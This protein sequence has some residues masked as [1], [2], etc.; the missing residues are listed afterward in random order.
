M[1]R[2]I[3]TISGILS[4]GLLSICLL[5]YRLYVIKLYCFHLIHLLHC[6][7]DTHISFIRYINVFCF[8]RFIIIPMFFF[9][10]FGEVVV[11]KFMLLSIFRLYFTR[12]YFILICLLSFYPNLGSFSFLSLIIIFD[13]SIEYLYH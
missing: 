13:L 11:G 3:I 12:I 7:L 10:G 4:I 6:H 1:H 8:F 2:W 5:S 9:I